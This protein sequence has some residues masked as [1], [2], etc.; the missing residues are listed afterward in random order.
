MLDAEQ[1]RRLERLVGALGLPVDL[2]RRLDEA[3]WGFVGAD[4]KRAGAQIR[5]V[6]PGPPG[7]TR[8]APLSVEAIRAAVAV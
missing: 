6:V 2:D 1:A 8:I 5:F 3:V 7:A 4:K